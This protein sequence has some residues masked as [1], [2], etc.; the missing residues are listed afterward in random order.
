MINQEFDGFVK[1]P[2]RLPPIAAILNGSAKTGPLTMA[3]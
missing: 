2:D 1:S 3:A